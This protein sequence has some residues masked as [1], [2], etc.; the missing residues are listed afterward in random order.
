MFNVYCVPVDLSF[1][2]SCEESLLSYFFK[3]LVAFWAG[4]PRPYSLDD[5]F[6]VFEM[7]DFSPFGI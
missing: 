6:A 7:L 1:R 2:T 4:R 5:S 3:S